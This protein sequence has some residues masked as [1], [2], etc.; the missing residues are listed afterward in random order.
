MATKDKAVKAEKPKATRT[1]LTTAERI[2]KLEAQAQEL[3]DR[4]VSAAKAKIAGVEEQLTKAR[5]RAKAA[6]VKVEDFE[7]ELEGLKA[8]AATA[9][10]AAPAEDSA[11]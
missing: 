8:L 11:A 1:V 5:E 7:R 3:R 10:E 9:D 2:A 4:E 6:T